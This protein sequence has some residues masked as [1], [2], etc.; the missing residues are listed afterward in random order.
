MFG[1]VISSPRG[2]LSLQQ[3]IY[4][5]NVY[6]ENASKS[7][8]PDIR[9]VLCHD[10]EISLNQ[11]KKAAKHTEDKAMR[12]GIA[13]IYSELGELMSHDGHGNEAQAF[14]NK[15]EKL[16]GHVR[17]S[18]KSTHSSRPS[19]IVHSIKSA[20][21]SI[22][23]IDKPTTPPSQSPYE[24]PLSIA[25]I[26][27]DIFPENVRPPTVA[28][29]APEPD[30]RLNDTRQLA[31]CLGLLQSSVEAGDI[32]DPAARTWLHVTKGELDEKERLEALA[33]DVIRAFKRD[34]FK[35]S[36][37]VT[38]VVYLAPVLEKDDFR[39]L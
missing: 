19:S 36:K 7:T 15:S 18:G 2:N 34:E 30:S 23:P 33:T 16:G 32:L 6:L 3:V 39:Y 21:H 4:L 11:A 29:T 17:K 14:Y 25:T 28:F 13:A 37:A 20:L 9:L 10:A 27:K 8:D 1:S 35:D 38:E 31:C 24:Q 5:A 26:P 12:E 22:G